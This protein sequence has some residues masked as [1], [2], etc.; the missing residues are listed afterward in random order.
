MSKN[1]IANLNEIESMKYTEKIA[2]KLNELL[3]KN[4]DAQKGYE[5]AHENTEN[6]TLKSFFKARSVERHHFV[7]ELRNH[8]K[9]YDE[10]PEKQTSI[11][12]EI[13]RGW[14]D[15]KTLFTNKN[16]EVLLEEVGRG[17]QAAIEEYARILSSNEL[18]SSTKDILLAQHTK[19]KEALHTVNNF[20]PVV[21]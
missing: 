9:N 12:G 21:F 14:M 1:S 16:E 2:K 7:Q 18:T 6:E 10:T 20:H 4:L 13:H 17:E 11:K 5:K 15:F 8:I 19:I 3:Q